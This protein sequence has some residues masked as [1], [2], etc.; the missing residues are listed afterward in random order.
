MLSFTKVTRNKLCWWILAV[1][2]QLVL[3]IPLMNR[4]F[5]ILSSARSGSTLL[6]FLLNGHP[7][8]T[9]MG[10]LLNRNYLQNNQLCRASSH[11]LVNYILASLLPLKL[12]LPFTGFKLFHEQMEFCNLRFKDILS[13]LLYPPVIVL[14]RENMLET[15]TSLQIAF[16]TDVWYSEGNTRRERIDIDWQEFVGY[17]K[18]LRERWKRSMMDIP[19]NSKVFFVSYEE[20]TANKDKTMNN[21]FQFLNLDNCYVDTTSKKQN[22]PLLMEK[23]INYKQ[24]EQLILQN[25]PNYTITKNWLKATWTTSKKTQDSNRKY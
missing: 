13:A 19:M 20:L 5:V 14:F 11:V 10:E 23:I 7:K 17:V 12:W 2:K 1:V 21:I 3:W 24:I 4:S 22:S 15:Y 16:K 25:Y 6:R 8:V 18:A 9:C